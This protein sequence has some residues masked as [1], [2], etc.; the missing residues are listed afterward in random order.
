M[1]VNTAAKFVVVVKGLPSAVV[2][3]LVWVGRIA[4]CMLPFAGLVADR[5]FAFDIGIDWDR[6]SSREVAM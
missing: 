2:V 3:H 6:W 5:K 1:V 4:F